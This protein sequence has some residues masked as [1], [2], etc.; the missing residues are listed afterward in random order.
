LV[1]SDRTKEVQLVKGELL[2][3][4]PVGA[5][6]IVETPVSQWYVRR[7]RIAFLTVS[8]VS[9]VVA[10]VVLSAL[11]PVVLA[12]VAGVVVGAVC[13]L[14]VGAVV[15][16]W[17][18][19]R[20]L[21]WWSVEIVAVAAAVLGPRMVAQATSPW[22]ALAAVLTLAGLCVLVHPVR[23]FLVA[24]V[25][26]LVVR[27]RLRLCFAGIVRGSGGLRPGSLPLVLWAKPT[28]AGERVWLWL[29]PGLDLAD[30]DG[31]TGRIAVACWAKDVRVVAASLRYAA[32][33]RV[34]VTRRDPFAEKV[35]SPLALLIPRPRTE[36]TAEPPVSPAVPRIGLELADIEEPAPEPP[37]RGGRR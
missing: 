11:V 23:R 4:R 25:W 16:V 35:P 1:L 26:C 22:L 13:G 3:G 20:V 30:L 14:L 36:K 17:P 2:G 32:L 10:T 37:T 19:L 21:W 6:T 31:K 9:A 15:R 18:V 34:D 12:V 5:I 29:R 33:I 27:H 24:W 7:A 8:I 28:P